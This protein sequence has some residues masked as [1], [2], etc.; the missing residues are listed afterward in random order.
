MKTFRVYQHPSGGMEAVK[1]GFSWPGF[2][3]GWIWAFVKGLPGYGVG[4][5]AL[6]AISVGVSVVSEVLGIIFALAGY[7]WAGLEGNEW[8]VQKLDARGYRIVNEVEAE[9]P[10]GATARALTAVRKTSPVHRQAPAV[11][12]AV[13]PSLPKGVRQRASD[14]RL[15]RD[16]PFCAEEIL[17]GAVVCRHCNRDVQPYEAPGAELL[18]GSGAQHHTARVLSDQ[19]RFCKVCEGPIP[20]GEAPVDRQGRYYCRAHAAYAR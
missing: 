7:V 10:D 15:V 1:E 13:P 14:A 20:A 18:P 8:R 11:S 16:C 17:A 9:T 3:F 6:V 12:G 2:F 5:L 19:K 4:L